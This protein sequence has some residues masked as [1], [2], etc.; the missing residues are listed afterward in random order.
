MKFFSIF[1]A[2]IVA[3]LHRGVDASLR[4]EHLDLDVE[5]ERVELMKYRLK[6]ENPYGPYSKWI[7]KPKKMAKHYGINPL[8]PDFKER[9]GISGF[10][11]WIVDSG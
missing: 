4:G 9:C 6:T 10:E 2:L 11:K 7:R 1:V 5:N 8:P 3:A